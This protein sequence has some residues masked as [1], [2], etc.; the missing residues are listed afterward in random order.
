MAISNSTGTDVDTDGY[1]Y[2]MHSEVF[3]LNNERLIK[4]MLQQN[5]ELQ[6]SLHCL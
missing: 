6:H 1:G 3:K 2:T 4:I 5:V